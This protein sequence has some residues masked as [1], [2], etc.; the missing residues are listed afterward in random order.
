M[1]SHN[2]P[3][4]TTPFIGRV[5][6]LEE[7]AQSLTNPACRLLNLVG[8]GGIGKTR[9]ALQATANQLAHYAD[10][11]YFV[12]LAPVNSPDL[13]A[14]AIAGALKVSFYSQE[15]PAVQLVRYLHDKPV[16]LLLDNFEHLLAATDLLVDLLAG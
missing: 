15:D 16:L 8:P 5:I 12:P 9:L 7:I 13:V 2:L 10:G 3:V 11:V 4:Q 6:E 1:P 14:S